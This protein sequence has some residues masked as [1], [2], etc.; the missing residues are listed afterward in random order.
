M[1]GN[2]LVLHKALAI[3]DIYITFTNCVSVGL[4]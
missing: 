4:S 3:N 2:N 1:T